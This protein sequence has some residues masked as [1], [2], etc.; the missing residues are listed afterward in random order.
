[1]APINR[2]VLQLVPAFVKCHNVHVVWA[3]ALEKQFLIA[4]LSV[5]VMVLFL[6]TDQDMF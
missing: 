4:S 2:N 1:M 5:V 6:S 3:S